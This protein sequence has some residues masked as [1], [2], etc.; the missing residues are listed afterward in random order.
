[1]KRLY[2]K[3]TDHNWLTDL[4]IGASRRIDHITILRSYPQSNTA[5][6]LYSFNL[7]IISSSYQKRFTYGTNSILPKMIPYSFSLGSPKTALTFSRHTM[8]RV[9][10]PSSRIEP[11]CSSYFPKSI[12]KQ[13]LYRNITMFWSI[14]PLQNPS[15]SYKRIQVSSREDSVAGRNSPT[16]LGKPTGDGSSTV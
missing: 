16:T 4:R 2:A 9:P 15:Y 13:K 11:I 7:G 8:G 14:R 5:I 10:M 3:D 1:M 12:F 6:Y